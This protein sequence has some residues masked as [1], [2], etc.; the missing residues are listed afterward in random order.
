MSSREEGN[1]SR[2]RE[3]FQTMTDLEKGFISLS[4]NPESI[5]FQGLSA[6]IQIIQGLLSYV[7]PHFKEVDA[8]GN[9]LKGNDTKAYKHVKTAYN[10]AIQFYNCRNNVPRRIRDNCLSYGIQ[11]CN[12]AF[13][14]LREHT[15]RMNFDFGSGDGQ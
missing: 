13:M 14:V 8:S 15:A 7:G 6:R 1:W 5:T 11:N 2:G 10:R 3:F 9:T 4:A 12:D